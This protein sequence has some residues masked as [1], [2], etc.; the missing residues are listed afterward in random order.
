MHQTI[1]ITEH[2]NPKTHGKEKGKSSILDEIQLFF[3]SKIKWVA[4]I[5]LIHM[6]FLVNAQTD[7]ILQDAVVGNAS[8]TATNSITMKAGFKTLPGSVFSASIGA[9]QTTGASLSITIPSSNTVPA[10]PTLGQNYVKTISYR[11]AKTAEPTG[12]FKN[13]EVIQ[14]FDGLGRPLQTVSVG[15]S[16]KANDIIV[17]TLYDTYGREVKKTLPYTD[18]NTGAFR[19][20]VTEAVVNSYYGTPAATPVGIITDNIAYTLVGYESSPL[21]RVVSQTGPGANWISKPATSNYH[22]NTEAKTGWTVTGDYSYSSF[23]FPTGSLLET[24]NSDEEGNTIREYKDKLGHVV[25]KESVLGT[26]VLRTAYIYDDYGLLRC[27]VPP[28]STDPNTTGLC[29]YYK[30]DNLNR[31]VE[32]KIPGGGIVKMVYDQRD[33][34][35]GSQ[36]SEQA[37]TNDWSFTKYDELNR[38]VITGLLKGYTGDVATGVITGTISESRNNV[39]AT[40]GYTNGTFPGSTLTTEVHSVNFYDDY[41]FILPANLNLNDS[42]NFA[43]YTDIYSFTSKKDDTPIGRVTGTMTKVLMGEI[44]SSI[45]TELYST[46]FYD[47]YGHVLRSISENHLF[48]KDVISN[49]YEDITYLLTQSRQEHYKGAEK[50]VIDKIM[51]YDHT[52]RLLAT[53]QNVN[54]QGEITLNAIQYNEVGEP[55]MK[56]LHSPQTSGIRSFLQKIDFQYN[57]RGWLTKINDPSLGSENDLFGMQINYNT[58]DNLGSLPSVK[59]LYNRNIAAIRWSTKGDL[60]RGYSFTYDMLNRLTNASYGDGASLGNNLN[61]FSESATEYDDNGNIKKLNRKFNNVLVDDLTYT[62]DPASPNQLKQINDAG[63][64]NT[65]VDDY[66]GDGKLSSIYTYDGNGNMNFDGGRNTSLAYHPSLNLIKYVDFGSSNLIYYYYSS[67][68]NKLVK[69][70]QAGST[71]TYTHYI[72]NVVYE[73]GKLSYIITE[74][75]RLVAIGD[76]TDRKFVNEYTIKDHLGNSR[77]AFMGSSLGGA[78]DLVQTTNYYPFGMVMNQSNSNSDPS[79]QKNKYLYNGKEL[80]NETLNGTFFGFLDYGKRFYDPQI[81]RWT[82]I[83]PLAEQYRRWSPYNYCMNNPIKFT[84]PDGSFVFLIPLI[85]I[86]VEAAI[87]ATVA[88]MAIYTAKVAHDKIVESGVL[89]LNTDHR[90][91]QKWREKQDQRTE[92]AG[93]KDVANHQKMVDD[94]VGKVNDRGGNTPSTPKGGGGKL[95]STVVKIGLASQFVEKWAKTIKPDNEEKTQQQNTNTNSQG[96]KQGNFT[97][98]NNSDSNQQNQAKDTPEFKPTPPVAVPQDVTNRPL[99]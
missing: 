5:L 41:D 89:S 90:A 18:S 37:K 54:N 45:K 78:I 36:N 73:K 4:A 7:V 20:G 96:Q 66:P 15:A 92:D 26:R 9:G 53:R 40:Y 52:G 83:D 67:E 38:P 44:N 76:G 88:V 91:A 55:I 56:C 49:N 71:N 80:Q 25:L 77:V 95:A 14:Y 31:M 3:H 46:I 35:R 47:K 81:A 94:G 69:H 8:V 27:V 62:Y 1:K 99:Y 11:E 17:P 97:N 61:Y 21:N 72:G 50:I 33:R 87:D 12:S 74:E 6:S 98:G 57:I 51:E 59:T 60:Q 58:N 82:T 19:S 30:Y 68:G 70:V 64:A 32:K 34:L 42:L 13:S 10:A 39:K 93:N 85:P 2:L 75:G 84:D 43:K 24:D 23:S 79:Y 86:V 28:T 29:Y 48:G 65:N 16:P 63:T 22:S